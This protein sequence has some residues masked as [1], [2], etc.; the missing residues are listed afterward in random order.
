MFADV[1]DLIH[2]AIE[3]ETVYLRESK[4]YGYI[5]PGKVAY[6]VHEEG[7]SAFYEDFH[8]GEFATQT[9]AIRKVRDMA[10]HYI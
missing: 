3:T 10:E 7:V 1:E 2:Q 4:R 8:L 9:E 6:I 5:K